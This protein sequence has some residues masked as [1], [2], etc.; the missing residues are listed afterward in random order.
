MDFLQLWGSC[1]GFRPSSR[2]V[3]GPQAEGDE[4]GPA[5]QHAPGWIAKQG[6]SAQQGRGKGVS[7]LEMG[8]DVKIKERKGPPPPT[9]KLHWNLPQGTGLTPATGQQSDFR[10]VALPLWLSVE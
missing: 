4:A 3:P 5:A 1:Q 9:E 2:G 10:Q 6:T 8:G 7:T